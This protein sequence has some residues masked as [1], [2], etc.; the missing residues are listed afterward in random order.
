MKIIE[1]T[2]GKVSLIDDDDFHLVGQYKWF[3]RNV[4][5]KFYAARNV[6]LNGRWTC[7]YMHSVIMGSLGVDHIDGNSL[8]NQRSNLRLSTQRDN[9]RN[10]G[11]SINNTSGYKGVCF[12]K[13]RKTP[14]LAQITVNYKKIH[15]GYF[16][17]PELAAGAYDKAATEFFGEFA[18]T[19]Q[20]MGLL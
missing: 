12:D 1:L 18:R 16:E 13:G 3:T 2:Q 20:M 10:K 6:K 5:D 7:E 4:Q 11:M 9:V 19:N 14:W 17:T 15:L 8:N